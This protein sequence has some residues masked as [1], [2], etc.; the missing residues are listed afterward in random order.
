MRAGALSVWRDGLGT[1]RSAIIAL[2]LA[3]PLIATPVL[4]A[5]KITDIVVADVNDF[6]GTAERIRAVTDRRP[7]CQQR[8]RRPVGRVDRAGP[9][10]LID[11]PPAGVGLAPRPQASRRAGRRVGPPSFR[12]D[13]PNGSELGI[14]RAPSHD[15]GIYCQPFAVARADAKWSCASERR[16]SLGGHCDIH[17]SRLDRG[18]L[19]DIGEQLVVATWADWRWR[20][21]HRD[22]GLAASALALSPGRAIIALVAFCIVGAV[23]KAPEPTVPMMGKTRAATQFFDG[24]YRWL[25]NRPDL[26]T[27]RNAEGRTR[28]SFPRLKA[29]ASM[30]RHTPIMRSAPSRRPAPAFSAH[31]FASVGVSGGAIGTALFAAAP[32]PV[33]V[34][35]GCAKAAAT[36]S[37]AAMQQDFL[38]PV[39]ANLLIVQPFALLTPGDQQVG[40]GGALLAETFVSGFSEL[41]ELKTGLAVLGSRTAIPLCRSTLPPTSLKAQE[42]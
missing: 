22:V 7:F 24:F 40:D 27:Y 4:G 17:H 29:A 14:F 21:G 5:C 6:K 19:P 28:S 35:I 10:S 3:G 32:N 36:A 9:G 12:V 18:Q 37:P 8:A 25:G 38:G 42:W 26:A 11:H 2:A 1:F 16:R 41:T 23:N 13:H 15:R 30:Q 39:V 20:P 31:L 33:P 34:E